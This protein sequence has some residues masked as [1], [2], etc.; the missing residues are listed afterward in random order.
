MKHEKKILD[1][2]TYDC[3]V[4]VKTNDGV[5]KT[6]NNVDNLEHLTKEVHFDAP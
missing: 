1:T 5:I 4:F 6:V 3:R 2:W